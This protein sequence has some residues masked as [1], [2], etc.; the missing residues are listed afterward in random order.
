MSLGLG[1][2]LSKSGLVTPGIVT[3]NLV[4][5]HNY[6]RKTAVPVSDGAARFIAAENTYIDLGE[7]TNFVPN[8]SPAASISCWFKSSD[9]STLSE[10]YGTFIGERT[11]DNML[12]CRTA[13]STGVSFLYS[14]T[15]GGAE[16]ECADNATNYFDQQWHFAVGTYS[17]GIGKL[18]IDGVLKDTQ[19]NSGV[20]TTLQ[21]DSVHC[22]VGSSSV[23]DRE[24]D[25]YV[26][27]GAI[28][29]R[30][31][32][33]AEIKSI[34]WKN[35]AGLT[36]SEKENLVSWWNLDSTI[37]STATLGNTVVYDNHNATLGDNLVNNPTLDGGVLSPWT[38]RHLNEAGEE[39]YTESAE[40]S[41]EQAYAGTYSIKVIAGNGGTGVNGLLTATTV[42]G[43]LYRFSAW[44]YVV[45][46]VVKINP[47]D[48]PF[49]SY[50]PSADEQVDSTTTGQWEQLVTYAWCD[51]AYDTTRT[52]IFIDSEG[53]A[54]V[55][56]IDNVEVQIVQGNPGELK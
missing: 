42:P 50:D 9:D 44:V 3:D 18:Y 40:I 54:A 53:G 34:M 46:G 17:L 31:L 48:G 2:S 38:G 22:T 10:A 33:Q 30:A 13:S 11:G 7:F 1:S 23:V 56:Y 5:K 49:G 8:A 47:P 26:C 6:R 36:P 4:M 32:T 14:E 15:N 24:F 55:F 12:L 39:A 28:W 52:T 19:D 45:S 16:N 20:D 29:T 51:T 25:G 43:K 35:Y 41:T 21:T 27:N 37:E